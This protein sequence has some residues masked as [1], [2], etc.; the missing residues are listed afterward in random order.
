MNDFGYNYRKK[1]PIF[2]PS[3]TI[4]RKCIRCGKDFETKSRTKRRC[5]P[6]QTI[7]LM[8]RGRIHDDGR[9]R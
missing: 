2:P 9:P 4:T 1:P 3:L 5:D 6:C 7:V 8:E